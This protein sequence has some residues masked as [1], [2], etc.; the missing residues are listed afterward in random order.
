MLA[1]QAKNSIVSAIEKGRFRYVPS[2]EE[3]GSVSSNTYLQEHQTKSDKV[4]LLVRKEKEE[5]YVIKAQSEH[6]PSISLGPYSYP[7]SR[8]LGLRILLTH[9]VEF[10]ENSTHFIRIVEHHIISW[11]NNFKTRIKG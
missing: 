11:P 6:V 2:E 8:W 5:E 4:S 3:C 1:Q 9:H 7:K 10:G